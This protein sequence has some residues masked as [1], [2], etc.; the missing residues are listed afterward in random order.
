MALL[1]FLLWIL[2][3]GRITLEI[4]LFGAAITAVLM[5]FAVRYLG[6]AP[7]TERNLYRYVP[8]YA[9]YGLN[10]VW[11]T[12]KAASGVLSIALR[13]HEHPTPVLVE[14]RSGLKKEYLNVILANSITLTPGT[15]TVF[16]E[17]DRFVVH[18]L[19]RE[20]AEGLDR[21]SFVRILR[22]FP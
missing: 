13:P 16:Q 8:L 5:V 1:I 19:R 3:N 22:K 11:E 18:A 15:I 7:E 10:L 12:V 2:F 9:L 4:L 14:F 6:Y 20:Y 17:Q 21:S